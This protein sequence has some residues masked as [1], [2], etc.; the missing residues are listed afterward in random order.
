MLE[1]E[2]CLI[3]KK[4]VLMNIYI[5]ILGE[6]MS[7][8]CGWIWVHKKKQVK[9]EIDKKN[10]FP[11]SITFQLLPAKLNDMNE[12]VDVQQ[13]THERTAIKYCTKVYSFFAKG[14]KNMLKAFCVVCGQMCNGMCVCVKIKVWSNF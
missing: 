14:E 10:W 11:V 12:T 2:A 3:Y 1:K 8:W 5:N 7:L 13:L 4:K 9:K 6:N